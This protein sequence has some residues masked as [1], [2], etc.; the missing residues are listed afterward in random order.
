MFTFVRMPWRVTTGL[1]AA[2]GVVWFVCPR[3][4]RAMAES[5]AQ[6]QVYQQSA[7]NA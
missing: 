3:I 5:E 7:A 6:W 4:D 1:L 2:L